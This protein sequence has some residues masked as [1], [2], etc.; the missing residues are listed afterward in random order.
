MAASKLK[1]TDAEICLSCLSVPIQTAKQ[2][3]GIR[4]ACRLGR[5]VLD[6]AHH[7]IRTG[8]TTDEIDKVVKQSS[9]ALHSRLY[10]VSS[11]VSNDIK[12]YRK[13]VQFNK[14]HFC[15]TSI[16]F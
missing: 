2:I 9:H 6:K 4:Q 14:I 5:E 1:V 15:Q 10:S 7:A 11:I 3:E 12:P 13:C 16:G 8:I